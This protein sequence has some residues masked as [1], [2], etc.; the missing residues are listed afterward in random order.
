MEIGGIASGDVAILF[1]TK[2]NGFCTTTLSTTSRRTV[3]GQGFCMR[4]PHSS[5]GEELL[6]AT[7]AAEGLATE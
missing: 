4:L 1:V 2:L 3:A 5:T 6:P 7:G